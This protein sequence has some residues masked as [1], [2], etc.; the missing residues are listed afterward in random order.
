MFQILIEPSLEA[1]MICSELGA[2]HNQ[3]TALCLSESNLK[4]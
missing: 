1:V 2:K 3:V 4:N